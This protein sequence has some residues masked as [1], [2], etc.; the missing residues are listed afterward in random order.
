MTIPQ[1]VDGHTVF[2]PE[3][4]DAMS[5]AF[6]GV[7]RELGLNNKVDP[8]TETVARQII[9]LARQGVRDPAKLR[10]GALRWFKQNGT[11]SD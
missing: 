3:D 11:T 2:S 1:F 4:L 7:L 6:E 8:V 9:S 10:E 5:A